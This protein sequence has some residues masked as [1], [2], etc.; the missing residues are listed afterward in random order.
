MIYSVKT[1]SPHEI[2]CVCTCTL[3]IIILFHI[4]RMPYPTF[5]GGAMAMTG[6]QI[7]AINGFPN[8]FYGWGGEDDD[9]YY[10]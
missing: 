4:F 8:R 10:R 6:Q 5:F 9:I 1:V 3:N 2:N 7:E